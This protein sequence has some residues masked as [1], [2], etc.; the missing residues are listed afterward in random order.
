MLV[1][2]VSMHIKAGEEKRF[3][4]AIE[5][6]AELSLSLEHG[7]LRFDVLRLNDD[8]SAYLLYEVYVDEP[9]FFKAHRSTPHFAEWAA[10]ATEV[11][12]GERVTTLATPVIPRLMA[13]VSHA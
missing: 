9:A 6:Q 3:L 2:M 5:R 1:V 7:C 13:E 11:L 4:A 10:T 8:S 12:D